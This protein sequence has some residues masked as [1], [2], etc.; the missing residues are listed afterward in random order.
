MTDFESRL[1][2]AALRG[3]QKGISREEQELAD[4]NRLDQLKN[5]HTSYRLKLTEKIERVVA[6]VADQFPGFLVTSVYGESGWGAACARDEL[7][8]ERGRRETKYSRFEMTVRPINTYMVLDLQCKGTI[9][10]RELLARNH[11]QP[12]GEVDIPS[13][14]SKL[15]QWAVTYVELFAANEREWSAIEN[16]F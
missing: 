11:F 5:L 15:E 9:A 4:R 12:L 6:K 13:F 14:E 7:R 3:A 2:E 1:K 8:M 16:R 10:N